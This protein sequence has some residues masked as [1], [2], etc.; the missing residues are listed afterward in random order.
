[1]LAPAARGE[2]LGANLTEAEK[3][4]ARSAGYEALELAPTKPLV[5][6]ETG[7]HTSAIWKMDVDA[8]NRLAATAAADDGSARLWNLRTGALLRTFRPPG[9]EALNSIALSPDGRLVACGGWTYGGSIYIFDAADGTMVK[10]IRGL[11]LTSGHLVYNHDGT[12][13]AG[14]IVSRPKEKIDGIF[15][16]PCWFVG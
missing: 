12:L 4:L 13:L 9:G 8:G 1:L 10:R 14:T 16:R 3:A 15:P 7:M 11:P 2:E 6:I 5:R